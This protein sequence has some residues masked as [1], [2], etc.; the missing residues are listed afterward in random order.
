MKKYTIFFIGLGLLGLILFQREVVLPFVYKVV[1]SDL[2]LVETDDKA[3]M[4][5]VVDEYTDMAFAQCNNYIKKELGDEFS[6]SFS[7]KAINAWSIGDHQYVINAE[8]EMSKANAENA[9]KRYVCRISYDKKTDQSGL[10]DSDNW[11]IYGLSGI[12]EI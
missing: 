12:D 5:S 8:V 4:E 6:L 2:F 11:S 3:Y 1:G 10:M 9:V 7:E